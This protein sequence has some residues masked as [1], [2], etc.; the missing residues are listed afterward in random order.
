MLKTPIHVLQA[1]LWHQSRV[2]LLGGSFNPPH[3]GHIHISRWALRMLHLD[4]VW[5]MV[6]PG[7][8]L[9]DPATYKP[10][11]ERLQ[12]AQDCLTD[13]PRLL[14]TDIE[15]ALGTA[16]SYDSLQALTRHFPQTSF[17]FLLGMDSALSFHRWY[18]WRD[19]PHLVPLAVFGRP[20]AVQIVKSCP[21]RRSQQY[22]HDMLSQAEF[23]DLAPSRCYWLHGGPLEDVSSTKIR[24]S[25]ENNAL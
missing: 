12:M 14:A 6:T 2:G 1:S 23:V 21:L 15:R 20:P 5:W 7:N 10:L 18:R 17:A 4:A 8:P 24:K 11:P 22:K 19:I 13:D 3:R 25:F 9:K 16:R